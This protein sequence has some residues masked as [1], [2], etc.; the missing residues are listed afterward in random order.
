MQTDANESPHKL[1]QVL[2][3]AEVAIQSDEP[4]RVRL[5]M[6]LKALAYEN[7]VLRVELEVRGRTV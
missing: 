1:R 4:D 6:L 2:E 5:G 7:E 3:I